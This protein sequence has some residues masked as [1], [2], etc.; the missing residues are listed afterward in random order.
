M[1][2][3]PP[4]QHAAYSLFQQPLPRCSVLPSFG[5]RT[6]AFEA[7][8]EPGSAS[9]PYTPTIYAGN[10]FPPPAGVA[11]QPGHLDCGPLFR[12]QG[13]GRRHSLARI[14][15]SEIHSR[16]TCSSSVLFHLLSLI[17]SLVVIAALIYCG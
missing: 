7:W 17:L 4:G 1:A 5:S 9:I 3:L 13:S 2:Q 14:R 16:F 10:L 11:G 15:R 12:R 8:L 6:L